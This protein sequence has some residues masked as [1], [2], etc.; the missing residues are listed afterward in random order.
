MLVCKHTT[1]VTVMS[2]AK[3]YLLHRSF[4]I[5]GNHAG[6][7]IDGMAKGARYHKPYSISLS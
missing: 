2:S 4:I 7:Q 6:T 3:Y 1:H 5:A